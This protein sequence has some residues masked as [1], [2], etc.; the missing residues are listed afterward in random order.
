MTLRTPLAQQDPGAGSASSA[1]THDHDLD[2]RGMLVDDT[3]RV[4]ERGEYNDCRAMLVIMEDRNVELL[5]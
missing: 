1:S 2:I 5:A 4:D 3:Q